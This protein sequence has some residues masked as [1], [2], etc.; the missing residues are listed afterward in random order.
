MEIPTTM[1]IPK[2]RRHLVWRTIIGLTLLVSPTLAVA[3]SPA[4][5]TA[6]DAEIKAL[7]GRMTLAEKVGQMTQPNIWRHQGSLGNPRPS[8]SA[9]S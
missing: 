8:S 6:H 7:V 5:L 4:W 9:P 3:A 1:P 2:P